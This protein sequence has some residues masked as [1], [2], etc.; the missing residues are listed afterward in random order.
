MLLAYVL[1]NNCSVYISNDNTLFHRL[2]SACNVEVTMDVLRMILENPQTGSS[3]FLA[4]E[5]TVTKNS[6]EQ[7]W[8]TFEVFYYIWNFELLQERSELTLFLVC[9][10]PC[11]FHDWLLMWACI[12]ALEAS[13]YVYTSEFSSLC[14][15]SH[16]DNVPLVELVPFFSPGISWL[17]WE[18]NLYLPWISTDH[19]SE[20]SQIV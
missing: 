12:C 18:I 7:L 1:T 6:A 20:W 3:M 8:M 11:I 5:V 13:K 19:H 15:L 9:R 4:A 10:S 2:R 16:R 14:F 17:P